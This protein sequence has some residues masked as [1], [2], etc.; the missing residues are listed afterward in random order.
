MLPKLMLTYTTNQLQKNSTMKRM[1]RSC[2][3][4]VE[5]RGL[6]SLSNRSRGLI[7][8]RSGSRASTQFIR[9]K[10]GPILSLKKNESVPHF[11]HVGVMD[12]QTQGRLLPSGTDLV[13]STHA[14][15]LRPQFLG[16]YPR[17]RLYR[18]LGCSVLVQVPI[19]SNS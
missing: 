6:N 2:I 3:I 17:V 16:F 9:E 13:D 4:T 1:Q 5:S 19:T 7:W 12:T 14:P 15:P 11:L 10:E 18:S 8:S